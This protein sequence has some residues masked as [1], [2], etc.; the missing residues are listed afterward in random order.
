MRFSAEDIFLR[1]RPTHRM[2]GGTA[3]MAH[4]S[5]W[6]TQGSRNARTRVFA[7]ISCPAMKKDAV[8]QVFISPGRPGKTHFCAF[9]RCG[10]PFHSPQGQD[11]DCCGLTQAAAGVFGRTPGGVP[12]VGTPVAR[13]WPLQ[14]G[15]PRWGPL[16]EGCGTK[17]ATPSG[18]VPPRWAPLP[19]GVAPRS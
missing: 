17:V 15:A 6:H 12:K 9:L 11:D 13:R 7:R 14:E 3:D 16:L 4:Q 8:C 1:P 2:R 5:T 19:E 18:G 10:A